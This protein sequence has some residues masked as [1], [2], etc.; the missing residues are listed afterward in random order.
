M[1]KKSFFRQKRTTSNFKFI[2]K[3]GFKRNMERLWFSTGTKEISF[4][5][6]QRAS[7]KPVL[8]ILKKFK[9]KL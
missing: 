1:K 6:Y 5:V 7:D 2:R 3:N 4:D 9:A 8:R